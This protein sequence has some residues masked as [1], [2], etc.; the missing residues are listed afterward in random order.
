MTVDSRRKQSFLRAYLLKEIYD[1]HFLHSG[2]TKGI[3]AHLKDEEIKL[4]LL[5]LAEKN[6]IELIN[7]DNPVFAEAKITSYGIDEVESQMQ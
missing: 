5:Y 4:A 7:L 6:F 2:F 3:S 1:F